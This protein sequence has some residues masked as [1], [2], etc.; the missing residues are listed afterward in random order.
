MRAVMRNKVC[1]LLGLNSNKSDNSCTY[2][3][4]I[5][6]PKS[7]QRCTLAAK[8]LV[9]VWERGQ[10]VPLYLKICMKRYIYLSSFVPKLK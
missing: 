3:S 8:T 2:A 7:L 9:I 4:I 10:L 6:H 5:K 1:S